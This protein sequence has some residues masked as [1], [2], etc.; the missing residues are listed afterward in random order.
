M[1]NIDPYQEFESND[2]EESYWC[3]AAAFVEKGPKISDHTEHNVDSDFEMQAEANGNAQ[4]RKQNNAPEAIVDVGCPESLGP[5]TTFQEA[6]DAMHRFA[7]AKLFKFS[8]R[9]T[10]MDKGTKNR[11]YGM[12]MCDK[13]REPPS[14]RMATKPTTMQNR[15]GSSKRAECPL[16]F[17]VGRNRKDKKFYIRPIET[18]HNHKLTQAYLDNHS[19]SKRLTKDQKEFTKTL[20]SAGVKPLNI[21]TSLRKHFQDAEN[22]DR[23][24]IYNEIQENRRRDVG[25]LTSVQSLLQVFI[26]KKIVQLCDLNEQQWQHGWLVF[27]TCRIFSLIQEV[28]P[29]CTYRFDIQNESL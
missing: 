5:Y 28:S 9:R 17:S 23:R 6:E 20:V 16:M 19:S 21:L 14:K 18:K 15:N 8:L 29:R 22:V 3:E 4:Q 27:S 11:R 2:H 25:D 1:S 26:S 13:G 7:P 10:K 24:N 12:F